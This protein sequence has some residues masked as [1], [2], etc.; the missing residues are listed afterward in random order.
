MPRKVLG[1]FPKGQRA[2]F[3]YVY[4]ARLSSA[5]LICILKDLTALLKEKQEE[6]ILQTV[7]RFVGGSVCAIAKAVGSGAQNG[8]TLPG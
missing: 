2:L 4:N 8:G 1:E 3:V 6:K 5:S 7:L